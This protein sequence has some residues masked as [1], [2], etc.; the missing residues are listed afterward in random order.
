M[1]IVRHVCLVVAS[2]LITAMAAA[3]PAGVEPDRMFRISGRVAPDEGS[4]SGPVQAVHLEVYD[5]ETGGTL[6]WSE[7]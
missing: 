1:T 6:L 2:C 4:A 5:A 7:L 3:Q